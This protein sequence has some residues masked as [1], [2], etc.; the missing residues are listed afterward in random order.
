M[1]IREPDQLVRAR[2]LPGRIVL[3]NGPELTSKAVVLWSTH[4]EVR[5]YLTESG[6]LIDIV[7][8]E[9]FIG[10]CCDSCLNQY[11]FTDLPDA[12]RTNN[13][14][15]FCYSEARSAVDCTASFRQYSPGKKPDWF[16]LSRW[17]WA[18]VRGLVRS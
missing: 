16:F 5:L 9:L 6:K 11:W 4:T 10:E 14:C 17:N 8:V 3:G 1:L 18:T 13:A 7:F 2:S 15:R 12:H